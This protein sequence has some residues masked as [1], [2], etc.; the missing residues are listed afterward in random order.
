LRLE[1][2]AVTTGFGLLPTLASNGYKVA[3]VNTAGTALIAS[4][5]LGVV[6]NDVVHRKGLKKI[7]D[8]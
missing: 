1:L 4:S 6:N 5:A 7:R 2:D 3:M 8:R